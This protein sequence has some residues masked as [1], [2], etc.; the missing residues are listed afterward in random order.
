[1]TLNGLQQRA[2]AM[3]REDPKRD[4]YEARSATGKHGSGQWFLTYANGQ[5]PQLSYTEVEELARSGHIE[6]R[7]PGCYRLASRASSAP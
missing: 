5:G 7:W 3:L 4:I 1:M 6:Q 2:L